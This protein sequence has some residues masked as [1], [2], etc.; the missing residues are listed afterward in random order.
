MSIRCRRSWLYANE[1]KE[2][3]LNELNEKYKF[4]NAKE[5]QKWRNIDGFLKEGSKI[6]LSN[7]T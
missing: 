5:V 4:E 1:R 7:E 6:V 2:T 3:M